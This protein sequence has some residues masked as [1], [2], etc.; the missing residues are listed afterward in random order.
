MPQPPRIRLI[1]DVLAPRGSPGKLLLTAAK[2]STDQRASSMTR[3]TPAPA[4]AVE[5][6][7]GGGRR[8][9]SATGGAGAD[10]ACMREASC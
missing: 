10:A 2:T 4:V 1:A 3:S 5:R 7:G 8:P 9:P 6:L